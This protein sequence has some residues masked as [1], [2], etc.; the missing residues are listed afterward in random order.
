M[1]DICQD[2]SAWD[3]LPT[4]RSWSSNQTVSL[5]G[6]RRHGYSEQNALRSVMVKRS[7]FSFPCF[8][9]EEAIRWSVSA[10]QRLTLASL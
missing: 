9:T 8:W 4:K 5:P 6:T 3:T 2:L 10:V 1:S 7:H